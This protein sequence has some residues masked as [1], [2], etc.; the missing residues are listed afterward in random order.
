[1]KHASARTFYV[2]LKHASFQHPFHQPLPQVSFT[3]HFYSPLWLSSSVR[4]SLA[5][6]VCPLP[7]TLPHAAFVSP[8]PWP[9]LPSALSANSFGAVLL[10]NPSTSLFLEPLPSAP[11]TILFQ[12]PVVRI[13][14]V[15]PFRVLLPCLPSAWPI[16]VTL[17]RATSAHLLFTP[18]LRAPSTRSLSRKLMINPLRTPLLCAFSLRHFSCL[19]L[20]SLFAS[21]PQATSMHFFLYHNLSQQL[22]ICPC[23]NEII[24]LIFEK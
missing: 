22:V 3:C 8:F 20:E 16:H 11:Y 17:P 4:H 5:L 18:I 1:M 12:P 24:K 6:S 13:S 2:A 15:G 23:F 9:F 21:L 14:S 19:F 7:A 10:F